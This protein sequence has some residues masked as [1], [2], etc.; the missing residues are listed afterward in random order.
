MSATLQPQ[1]ATSENIKEEEGVVDRKTMRRVVSASAIGTTLEWYDH[2]IYGSAATL[3][4]PHLFFPE[5]DPLTAML[6]SLITYSV[7]FVT[8]PLGAA[9]F[10]QF[11]DKY[12]RKNILVITLV[13]MGT[14]T[15]LIGL[16]PT[17]SS[18]GFVAPLLLVA[19]RFIQGIGLGGEWGGAALL[20]AEYSKTGKRGLLGSLIQIA[21]PIG[22]LIANAVFS[23]ITYIVS[24]D[25]FMSWG[26]RVPFLSSALLVLVGVWLRVHIKESPLFEEQTDARTRSPIADVIKHHWK[27]LLIAIGSRV[28]SDSIFYLFNIF[29][30]V[31]GSTVLH[32]D[33]KIL[34]DAVIFGA[35]TQAIMVPIWGHMA[36]KW[37]RRPILILGA[38]GAIA[39]IIAYFPLM[40]AGS[41]ALVFLVPILGNFFIAAMWGPLASFMPELFPTEVRYTGAGLGFQSAGIFGG[42]LAPI[43]TAWLLK[44]Y[45]GSVMPIVA[46]FIALIAILI[47]CVLLA[48]ETAHIDLRDA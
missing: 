13:M 15:A 31:Y 11:G 24:E 26:W 45:P 4:F 16:V 19:L 1:I 40:S 44:A 48:K 47:L 46:Y 3:V 34:L 20:V 36:D 10:G 41:A 35:V 28:G 38:I 43:V 32:Y 22:L 17:Y 23:V 29:I 8:R 30:L 21:S 12:G 7:A 39:A 27:R 9:I 25:A 14:A 18:I 2:F 42:A 6:L 33:R 5:S 37:G